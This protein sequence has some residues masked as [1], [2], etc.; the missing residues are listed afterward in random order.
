MY[1]SDIGGEKYTFKQSDTGL[2]EQ[3]HDTWKYDK[4]FDIPE[5]DRKYLLAGLKS[6]VVGNLSSGQAVVRS[7]HQ[8]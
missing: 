1:F 7:L 6:Q 3:G 4:Y 2:E 8:F 5:E